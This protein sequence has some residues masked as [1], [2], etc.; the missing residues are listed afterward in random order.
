MV[1]LGHI[2][3]MNVNVDN[4]GLQVG[5]KVMNNPSLVEDHKHKTIVYI[6]CCSVAAYVPTNMI[7]EVAKKYKINI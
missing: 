7:L 1:I 5:F 4:C 3:I 2:S 6:M